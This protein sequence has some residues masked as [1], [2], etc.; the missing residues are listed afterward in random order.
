MLYVTQAYSRSTIS[1]NLVHVWQYMYF[2][3]K[4][5]HRAADILLKGMKAYCIHYSSRLYCY[6]IIPHLFLVFCKICGKWR[7]RNKLKE[8]KNIYNTYTVM[9]AHTVHDV[10]NMIH[11]YSRMIRLYTICRATII[12]VF[13]WHWERKSGSTQSIFC[14]ELTCWAIPIY[15]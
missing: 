6:P 10:I 5:W 2:S 8:I 14:I 13:P 4:V 12:P 15:L 11:G 9:F 3:T 7:D 1:I